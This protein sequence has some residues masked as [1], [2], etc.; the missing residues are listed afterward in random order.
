MKNIIL[1]F[2]EHLINASII[3][4]KWPLWKQNIFEESPE[5]ENILKFKEFNEIEKIVKELFPSLIYYSLY[6]DTGI[7]KFRISGTKL[8]D[9]NNLRKQTNCNIIIQACDSTSLNIT[10]VKK[11]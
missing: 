6:P 5:N 4:Q 2:K 10:L 3:V 1:D 9:L 11:S 8:E 7:I